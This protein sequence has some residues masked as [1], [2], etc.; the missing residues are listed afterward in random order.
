V[1]DRL[2]VCR[3]GSVWRRGGAV[4]F[5][6]RARRTNERKEGVWKMAALRL[7]SE[8]GEVC[9]MGGGLGA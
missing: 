6:C 4:R 7:G 1:V 9:H 5:W 2:T 3:S 8:N